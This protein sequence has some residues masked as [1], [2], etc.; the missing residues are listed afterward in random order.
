[1]IL[2]R[3]VY[4][5]RC[6]MYY[7]IRKTIRSRTEHVSASIARL[8]SDSWSSCIDCRRVVRASFAR[9][10]CRHASSVRQSSA[11]KHMIFTVTIVRVQSTTTAPA[12]AIV[13]RDRHPVMHRVLRFC[14]TG[15]LYGSHNRLFSRLYVAPACVEVRGQCPLR[16]DA[17]DD[18][19]AHKLLMVTAALRR[20][21]SD[22]HF[23]H[24]YSPSLERK[25]VNKHS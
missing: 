24:F 3:L 2:Y 25:K 22:I 11:A 4:C 19:D 9:L 5:Y 15:R 17:V 12:A 16:T 14:T 7:G 18:N 21:N 6:G 23:K 20:R 13:A 8:V 10:R 1:M